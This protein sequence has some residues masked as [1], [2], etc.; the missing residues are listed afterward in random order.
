MKI[1]RMVQVQTALNYCEMN[2][3]KPWSTGRPTNSNSK[4]VQLERQ[5]NKKFAGNQKKSRRGLRGGFRF[6]KIFLEVVFGRG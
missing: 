3:E 4:R 6:L 2:E 1:F 5:E